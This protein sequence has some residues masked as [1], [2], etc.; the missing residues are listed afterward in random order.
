MV[1]LFDRNAHFLL[2]PFCG[3]FKEGLMLLPKT[4]FLFSTCLVVVDFL[5]C[6][7]Y[8]GPG[9]SGLSEKEMCR[10]E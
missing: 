4:G 6:T 10:Y 3:N 7:V 5:R 2:S 9:K 1:Q 8:L